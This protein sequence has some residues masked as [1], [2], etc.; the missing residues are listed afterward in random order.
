[1]SIEH[2]GRGVYDSQGRPI[3]SE[4][5]TDGERRILVSTSPT[6]GAGFQAGTQTLESHLLREILTEQRITNKYLALYF[7]V[8]LT[9]R[10]L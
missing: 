6:P 7:G 10:D 1:M 2:N 3:G 8:V 9:E 5:D 4:T